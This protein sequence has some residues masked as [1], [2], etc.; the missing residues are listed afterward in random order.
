[1]TNTLPK[2]FLIKMSSRV[3]HDAVAVICSVNLP[4]CAEA[5]ARGA[6]YDD[7]NLVSTYQGGQFRRRKFSQILRHNLGNLNQILSEYCHC[8]F[9]KVDCRQAFQPSPFHSEG[10]SPATAKKI[11]VREWFD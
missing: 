9:I 1:M 4:Y 3:F 5:L 7:I 6:S 11:D 8:L 10:E 2:E